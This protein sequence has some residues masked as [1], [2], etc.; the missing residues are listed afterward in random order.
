MLFPNPASDKIQFQILRRDERYDLEL[1]D[2][3]GK[4]IV[5]RPAI[6][7]N[8]DENNTVDISMLNSGIYFLKIT[9]LTTGDLL[10]GRFVK[11]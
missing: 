4:E 1:F 11:K 2:I 5:I 10:Y 8:A 9:S 6:Q 7:I 3:I